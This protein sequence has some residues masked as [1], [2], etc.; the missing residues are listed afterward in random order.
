[1]THHQCTAA[2]ILA[3]CIH[4]C[5][6]LLCK[7]GLQHACVSAVT[8]MKICCSYK[9]A[10]TH[11]QCTAALILAICIHHCPVLLCN[12]GSQ[13][14][15]VTAITPMMICCFIQVCSKPPP[16]HCSTGFGKLHSPLSSA[17]L[18]NRLKGCLCHCNYTYEDLL[19][20]QVCNDPPPMHCSFDFG[21]L[22][23]PLSSAA[24]QYRLTACLC[25]CNYTYEDL[26][27]HTSVQ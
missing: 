5:P 18:Q 23:S 3:I 13:H 4:H 8:P 25:H 14:A 21:N 7:T 15:C 27:L 6:V 20:I 17:A 24:L 12:T 10:M 22:H 16:M 1:M 19:L 9:C 2:L 26:L 11:H